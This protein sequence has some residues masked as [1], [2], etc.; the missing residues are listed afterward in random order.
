MKRYPYNM[1]HSLFKILFSCSVVFSCSLLAKQPSPQ[2]QIPNSV[3]SSD[4]GAIATVHPIATQFAAQQLESGG[5][6]IDAAIAAAL[7]L[8]V[9][10]GYNSGI[11][12][13]LFALVH[14][15]NGSIEAI[16]AR[17]M[18]PA[19]AHR[20]MY[21]SIDNAG[22]KTLNKNLSKVGA[23]AIGI[24]GSVAAFEY[25]ANK[26][27]K[28]TL[29]SL[30]SGAAT[31]ADKGFDVSVDYHR[32]LKRTQKHLKDFPASAQ[33]FLTA[34]HQPLPIGSLL[35]QPDLARTYRQLA[36]QGKDYFYTG[37]FAKKTAAWMRK[38]HGIITQQDFINYEL[39]V[40]EPINSQFLD[41]QI[42]GF[43]PPSS[44]G[45]HVAQILNLLAAHDFQTLSLTG[46]QHVLVES[47]KLAFAD[48]AYWLGD[49]DFTQVPKGL[50][51]Q[52]YAQT[53]SKKID[54][55]KA[56]HVKAHSTPD[57]AQEDLFGKHTTHISVA[58]KQG[59]WVSMT[60]TINTTFGSKVVIPNTGVL[61]NNQMDDFAA[62]PSVPNAFGLVGNDANSIQP[63]KRPLSS[64][65]PTLVLK[66]GKPI[67]AI[68]AAGG[69]MIITQVTQALVNYLGEGDSL[70]T[71]IA[72]PR[73]HQQWLP[74]KVFFDKTLPQPQQ[75]ALNSKGH[76]LKKL[77]FEGSTNA[78]SFKD[79][80]FQA[81]SEPRLVERQTHH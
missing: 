74:K 25:L 62:Q 65:S 29:A 54:S 24:P 1:I 39:K 47:M 75:T 26:G 2:Q 4:L 35:Q 64:M 38:N 7:A 51:S 71:A 63:K 27:G 49:S 73:I 61:M 21:V 43:P 78:V 50:I 69:P 32:R 40:R 58:D 14:W 30:Y 77:R 56:N 48:R 36:K 6:A 55:T 11:G 20:D 8:G 52:S 79:G 41:Y 33:I 13:G 80:L 70:Y 34:K 76:T 5:N 44:G 28:K 16:D 17:E 10:D 57:N 18:A 81:V 72:K 22:K 23:L 19:K 60:T 67:L 53:L 37:E 9:V 3:Y 31:I 45:I 59:N 46:Y 42:Y 68:G 66:N 12:G 15:K